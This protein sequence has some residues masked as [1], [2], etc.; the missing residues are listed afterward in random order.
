MRTHVHSLTACSHTHTHTHTHSH[1]HTQ[2]HSALAH[3]PADSHSSPNKHTHSLKTLHNTHIHM[4]H[5]LP[6]P[7]TLVKIL[8]W[9]TEGPPGMQGPGPCLHRCHWGACHLHTTTP[10]TLAS[11][12]FWKCCT[13]ST[14]NPDGPTDGNSQCTWKEA[15]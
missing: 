13:S 2:A 15:S 11:S 7:R 9:C 1:G 5:G 3:S 4:R 10:V 14:T 12:Y 6:A 8:L